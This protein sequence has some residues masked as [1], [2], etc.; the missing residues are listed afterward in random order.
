MK[1]RWLSFVLT[2]FLSL[3]AISAWLIANPI[4]AFAATCCAECPGKT[5]ACCS[6]AICSARDG[7]GCEAESAGGS[8]SEN[9]CVNQE[10]EIE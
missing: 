4:P 1:K 9:L 6:G 10:L 3:I 2:V 7:V 8:K 5:P